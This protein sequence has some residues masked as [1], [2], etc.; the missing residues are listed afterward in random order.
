MTSETAQCAIRLENKVLARHAAPLP[1]FREDRWP[2]A[3]GG[4]GG[5]NRGGLGRDGGRGKLRHAH[6]S[7]MQRLSHAQAPGPDPF[8]EEL[9]EIPAPGGKTAPS[10]C[11]L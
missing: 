1:G 9:P 4:S 3:R 2:I 5:N 10:V 6:G 8:A 7:G 11:A